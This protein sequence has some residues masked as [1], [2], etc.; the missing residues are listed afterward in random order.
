MGA[1]RFD[2]V[3]DNEDVKAQVG[4]GNAAVEQGA[5]FTFSM[6]VKDSGGSVLD[7]TG[8]AARMTIRKNKNDATPIDELTS[9]SEITLDG[10]NDPNLTVTIA[11]SVTAAYDWNGYAH[12]DLEIDDQDVTPVVTRLLYGL[13]ELVKEATY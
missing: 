13:I 11:A 4:N 1:F 10:T 2:F 12:Y 9:A 6:L 3:E 5:T 8:Y 7:L